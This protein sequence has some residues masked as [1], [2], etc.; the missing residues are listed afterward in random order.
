[1]AV[2]VLIATDVRAKQNIEIIMKKLLANSLLALASAGL[3]LTASPAKADT[4][5]LYS[6]TYGPATTEWSRNFIL[7]LFNPSLGSLTAV[8]IAASEAVNMSGSVSNRAASTENFKITEGSQLTVTIPGS[9]I[10]LSPSPTALGV[11]YTL[12]SHTS[13]G[14]G[15]ATPSDS[16][17]YTYTAPA[18]LAAFVGVGTFTA[19]GFTANITQIIGGGGN[20]DTSIST[21][22]TGS[23][24]VQYTYVPIPEP[25]SLTLLVLGGAAMLLRKRR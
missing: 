15:P 1:L 4:T 11:T 16:V 10:F 12:A 20:I 25:G 13:A 17:N 19:P 14:Y 23:V 22:A 21:L 24:S 9:L 18:D 2:K 6:D 5:P 3:L 8:Y 7:P